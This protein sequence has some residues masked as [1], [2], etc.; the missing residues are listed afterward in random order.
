ML[1]DKKKPQTHQKTNKNPKQKQNKK[2]QPTTTGSL[3]SDFS[4]C[5]KSLWVILKYI[6]MLLE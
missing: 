3:S 6:K 1:W 2:T 4:I 5:N